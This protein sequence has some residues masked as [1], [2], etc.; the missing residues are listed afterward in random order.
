M[1]DVQLLQAVP[2][3]RL[4][5]QSLAGG[6]DGAIILQGVQGIRAEHSHVTGALVCFGCGTLTAINKDQGPGRQSAG[7]HAALYAI[8]TPHHLILALPTRH[9]QLSSSARPLDHFTGRR[10]LGISSSI[11]FCHRRYACAIHF[12]PVFLLCRVRRVHRQAV[13][14]IQQQR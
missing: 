14:L 9:L 6:T 3:R 2:L 7:G 11:Q 1:P 5:P 12:P 10:R 13:Q 4:T 8:S